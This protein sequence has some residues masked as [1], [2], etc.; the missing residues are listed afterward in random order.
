MCHAKLYIH[1]CSDYTNLASSGSGSI[2]HSLEQVR[3]TYHVFQT[4]DGGN[5]TN[6]YG[7]MTI[8]TSLGSSSSTKVKKWVSVLYLKC[9]I[10]ALDVLLAVL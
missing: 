1:C 10:I 3:N 2:K 7:F 6:I 9:R 8:Y 4:Q 5:V